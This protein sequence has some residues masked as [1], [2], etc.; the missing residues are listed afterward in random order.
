MAGSFSGVAT[1]EIYRH[2]LDFIYLDTRS[3]ARLQNA[4]RH[5]RNHCNVEELL[6]Q[7]VLHIDLT[8]A[9]VEVD[10]A[11]DLKVSV[12]E[13]TISHG[14]AERASLLDD[15]F[16]VCRSLQHIHL[17][18][19]PDPAWFIAE[20]VEGMEDDELLDVVEKQEIAVG[21]SV[22]LMFAKLAKSFGHREPV[23]LDGCVDAIL[24][25]LRDD[26]W[27]PGLC[28]VSLFELMGPW[29]SLGDH[30]EIVLMRRA[31]GHVPDKRSLIGKADMH[32][33]F[34]NEDD[35]S[36]ELQWRKASASYGFIYVGLPHQPVQGFFDLIHAVPAKP[37]R[38]R[39]ASFLSHYAAGGEQTSGFLELSVQIAN[40]FPSFARLA[41]ADFACRFIQ[42]NPE[43]G[44]N[45][46]CEA[47]RVYYEDIAEDIPRIRELA[48]DLEGHVD[49]ES[50]CTTDFSDFDEEVYARGDRM[51]RA[52]K[53]CGHGIN[54][55]RFF[56]PKFDGEETEAQIEV[57]NSVLKDLTPMQPG[58]AAQTWA[59]LAG[60]ARGRPDIKWLGRVVYGP[61]CGPPSRQYWND[62]RIIHAGEMTDLQNEGHRLRF[63]EKCMKYG[64]IDICVVTL[65]VWPVG[66]RV[67]YHGVL[68]LFAEVRCMRSFEHYWPKTA[69]F[70]QGENYAKWVQPHTSVS[71]QDAANS[72]LS[73]FS[74]FDVREPGVAE[75][76]R[77][78]R[79]V[80]MAEPTI[81]SGVC[82]DS[83]SAWDNLF[84]RGTH[85]GREGLQA[86]DLMLRH[87]PRISNEARGGENE[88]QVLRSQWERSGGL[89]DNGGP[90]VEG[91]LE[92]F[93][94]RCEEM[95]A[96][97]PEGLKVLRA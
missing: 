85:R 49:E 75:A 57:Q 84:G 30:L 56:L 28:S 52:T 23:H 91:S 80:L 1:H 36:S 35:V 27:S 43:H 77:K 2:I 10:T 65:N 29:G 18:L 63:G 83:C 45:M 31:M 25:A 32:V 26:S 55:P 12:L 19:V 13:V 62:F 46:A 20:W 82:Q 50:E 59:E 4:S 64:S 73:R 6:L 9:E 68:D 33:V 78:C 40:V 41:G 14:L 15:V 3:L 8:A 88:A 87:G 11:Q 21:D 90:A 89:G 97:T 7:R 93:V 16:S 81:K 61:W 37:V 38:A 22:G 60:I 48:G 67:G 34:M 53:G 96:F 44:S 54:I 66:E 79:L 69:Y 5:L 47:L 92:A 58:V 74:T 95:N 71:R 39:A 86:Y 17:R 42:A 94:Q 76:I 72:L 24:R 70:L 51:N